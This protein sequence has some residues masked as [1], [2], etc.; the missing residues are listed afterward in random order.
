M[1]AILPLVTLHTCKK[2]VRL[3]FADTK[4]IEFV[5]MTLRGEDRLTKLWAIHALGKRKDELGDRKD[6]AVAALVR[7]LKEEERLSSKPIDDEELERIGFVQRIAAEVLA[8]IE[9]RKAMPHLIEALDDNPYCNV[10]HTAVIALGGIGG[11]KTIPPLIRALRD[12]ERVVQMAAEMVLKGSEDPRAALALVEQRH[13]SPHL[14]DDPESFP[15]IHGVVQTDEDIA[16]HITR[17]VRQGNTSILGDVMASRNEKLKRIARKIME[18]KEKPK[19]LVADTVDIEYLLERMRGDDRTLK[20]WAIH[21]IG[22]RKDELSDRK[23]E[24]VDDLLKIIEEEREKRHKIAEPEELERVDFV[25]KGAVEVLGKLEDREAIPY[26]IET[27]DN[28]PYSGARYAATVALG[29]FGG[30]ETIP[31][32]IRALR[33]E[34]SLVREGAKMCLT[35]TGMDDPRVAL[36]L[37]EQEHF[38]PREKD[39]PESLPEAIGAIQTAKD[40]DTHIVELID[41]SDL[42]VLESVLNSENKKLKEIARNIIELYATLPGQQPIRDLLGGSDEDEGPGGS[43][44]PTIHAFNMKSARSWAKGSAIFQICAAGLVVFGLFIENSFWKYLTVS[45]GVILGIYF[46]LAVRR[47]LFLAKSVHDAFLKEGI[48]KDRI[49]YKVIADYYGFRHKAFSHLPPKAKKLIDIHEFYERATKS[50][51][52]GMLATLPLV[53][54]F[55][56]RKAVKPKLADTKPIE[57][58]VPMLRSKDHLV[59]H[60]AIR[61]LGKRKDEL[62]DKKDEVVAALARSLREEEKLSSKPIDDA[63]FESIGFA[64]KAA[65]EF[66]PQIEGRKAIPLL[67]EALDVNPY[68]NVRYTAVTALG[69]L[70]GEET[71]PPLIRALRDDEIS[72]QVAAEKALEHS[73]DPKAVLALIEQKHFP[74]HRKNDPGSFPEAHGVVQADGDIARH[75]A[76]L[77]DQ[78]NI[79]TLIALQESGNEELRKITR[80]EAVPRL[81]KILDNAPGFNERYNAVIV[82]DKLGGEEIIPPLIR[83]LRDDSTFVRKGAE[84][85]L[86]SIDDPR[87]A[88]ALIE[89]ER[90][91]PRQ[92]DSPKSLPEAIGTIQTAKDIDM[93]I[94]ELIDRSDLETLKAVLGSKNAKLRETARNTIELYATLPEQQPIRDL[95]EDKDPGGSSLPA[96]LMTFIISAIAWGGVIYLTINGIQTVSAENLLAGVSHTEAGIFGSPLGAVLFLAISFI[97]SAIYLSFSAARV[98]RQEEPDEDLLDR[99]WPRFTPTK[100]VR[101]QLLKVLRSMYPEEKNFGAFIRKIENPPVPRELRDRVLSIVQASDSLL[102]YLFKITDLYTLV[103]KQEES[104]DE[105]KAHFYMY[106]PKDIG[107]QKVTRIIVAS[108]DRTRLLSGCS[109][110]ISETMADLLGREINIPEYCHT[111]HE[112]GISLLYFDIQDAKTG[113][114]LTPKQIEA[115]YENLPD[116]MTGVRKEDLR[117]PAEEAMKRVLR[118]FAPHKDKVDAEDAEEMVLTA[119]RTGKDRVVEGYAYILP[120]V[121]SVL[122]EDNICLPW[123]SKRLVGLKIAATVYDLERALESLLEKHGMTPSSEYGSIF[124]APMLSLVERITRPNRQ[125]AMQRILILCRSIVEEAVMEG[126]N[127]KKI[128]GILKERLDEEVTQYE[129]VNEGMVNEIRQLG[130]ELIEEFLKNREN[131][132][133]NEVPEEQRKL[134]MVFRNVKRELNRLFSRSKAST[135]NKELYEMI[136]GDIVRQTSRLI[137][138]KKRTAAFCLL[139]FIQA[140]EDVLKGMA[141][142]KNEDDMRDIITQALLAVGRLEAQ[143]SLNGFM[144]D[145]MIEMEVRMLR[146]SLEAVRKVHDRYK[147]TGSESP[148]STKFIEALEKEGQRNIEGG[149]NAARIVI[150]IMEELLE[151]DPAMSRERKT[152]IETTADHIIEALNSIRI[153]DDTN[154]LVKDEVPIIIVTRSF[155]MLWAMK[156]FRESPQVKGI[157]VDGGNPTT[158][159]VIV[160][161]KKVPVM[162]GARAGKDKATDAIIDGDRIIIDEIDGKIFVNPSFQAEEAMDIKRAES[163]LLEYEAN[164]DKEKPAV[165]IDGA[166][167]EF[168]VDI[169]DPAEFTEDS[170]R[171]FENIGLLRSEVLY[172]ERHPNENELVR[173]FTDVA[174]KTR[175]IVTVRMF[176]MQPDKKPEYFPDTERKGTDYLLND[177][178]GMEIAG[179]LAR[180]VVKAYYRFKENNEEKGRGIRILFPNVM[181]GE[182]AFLSVEL[183]RQVELEIRGQMPEQLVER[184]PVM[185]IGGMIEV[186]EAVKK[187]REIVKAFDFISIGTSDLVNSIKGIDDRTIVIEDESFTQL[188]PEFDLHVASIFETTSKTGKELCLC[189]EW[190]DYFKTVLVVLNASKKH[191]GEIVLTAEPDIAVTLKHLIRHANVEK[192]MKKVESAR[193]RPSAFDKALE[194]ISEDIR[195]QTIVEAFEKSIQR[196]AT[197][198]RARSDTDTLERAGTDNGLST[199]E[200]GRLPGPGSVRTSV[201]VAVAAVTAILGIPMIFVSEYIG[202]VEALAFG[203]KMLFPAGACFVGLALT[204]EFIKE[205]KRI[206][207]IRDIRRRFPGNL[208]ELI[209]TGRTTV[210]AG[211][212]EEFMFLLNWAKDLAGNDFTITVRNGGKSV[213]YIDVFGDNIFYSFDSMY[214]TQRDDALHIYRD[215][216]KE[217]TGIGR[218]LM[219]LAMGVSKYKGYKQFKVLLS[220]MDGFYVNIGFYRNPEDERQF[221]YDLESRLLPKIGIE[222]SQTPD[223]VL[224]VPDT[225]GN[226]DAMERIRRK[227]E[228]VQER[229]PERMKVIFYECRGDDT[230]N[231]KAVEEYAKRKGARMAIPVREDITE[232]ELV[233]EIDAGFLEYVATDLFKLVNPGLADLDATRAKLMDEAELRKIS[234]RMLK[235]L[236]RIAAERLSVKSAYFMNWRMRNTVS[237]IMAMQEGLSGEAKTNLKNQIWRKVV[238]AKVKTLGEAKMIAEAH[239]RRMRG[240]GFRLKENYPVKLKVILDADSDGAARVRDNKQEII[241]EMDTDGVL[242]IDD[243]VLGKT[244]SEVC[245]EVIGDK[246]RPADVVVI[247]EL[248]KSRKD[249]GVPEEVTLIEYADGVMSPEAYDVSLEILVRADLPGVLESYLEEANIVPGG[250]KLWF[251]LP[252]VD[253]YKIEQLKHEAEEYHKVLIMA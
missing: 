193:K 29:K 116:H 90:F 247:D 157:I 3:Q 189:G 230:R 49:I 48:E 14:K 231:T 86:R 203:I 162:T 213:G 216:R 32:L 176:D 69:E 56:Y 182:E 211:D 110:F 98:A 139:E 2:A 11:E 188:P 18:P 51:F 96:T 94:V 125:G 127:A 186:V 52:K 132:S 43:S 81:I 76:K 71:V 141:G 223:I 79:G 82:M 165:S 53:T 24:I 183:I 131:I 104:K 36:A 19:P 58:I 159:W 111:D 66:L 64:Q 243:I 241:E 168:S 155:N 242:E 124:T 30:E 75:I 72:V 91:K 221:I 146:D 108:N 80:K 129:G 55:T 181:N 106:N 7:S 41:R 63:E 70:G 167:V 23:G 210:V 40:I 164:M 187:R 1:L 60:W 45:A 101:R 13:F 44:L 137:A 217:Y 120:E 145:Q 227:V 134:E 123:D 102:P 224:G 17:F 15:E 67:I 191:K 240:L 77:A 151:E 212:G 235:I 25:R 34:E 65:A 97:V 229:M 4:P 153:L 177:P 148:Y 220:R 135:E 12:D 233:K 250:G 31:P 27:L 174:K 88:L 200:S 219:S 179:Q 152:K 158:H 163:T 253:K 198:R 115:F 147:V 121:N 234:E 46:T 169:T 95:L 228:S 22:K 202:S 28:D 85:C 50:H 20:L 118:E 252:K 244:T 136:L 245:R 251:I 204:R 140:N 99:A 154:H 128:R 130:D 89:Q 35:G 6:E 109:T 172:Q 74:P 105:A 61:A 21:A 122:F 205:V 100:R 236:P 184:I 47:Y 175:G 178:Y 194:K 103:K 93:H 150:E 209:I 119:N 225:I 166:K 83:A 222:K 238:I 9:G 133:E 117:A 208:G 192:E 78:G 156:L 206:I 201:L 197:E 144:K 92:K 10:R 87:A 37:V 207:R 39:R 171:G 218:T 54:L 126:K 161:K 73:R 42:K 190:L 107:Y 214:E 62:G 239:G 195:E 113:R 16:D 160:A 8:K 226:E 185:S 149:K 249:K 38:Q 142:E 5:I 59:K 248:K 237:R 180:A 68:P 57:F 215:Y 143:V 84:K 170:M 114:A 33:D 138:K 112:N 232:E 26:L 199:S 246:H 196:I 173:I